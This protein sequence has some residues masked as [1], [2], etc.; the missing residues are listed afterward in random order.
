[1]ADAIN[2]LAIVASPQVMAQRYANPVALPPKK[3]SNRYHPPKWR[4][5]TRVLAFTP[6][7]NTWINSI[8][9]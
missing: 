4:P 5:L 2:Y 6:F 9:N 7:Y 8:Q 1:M 3:P